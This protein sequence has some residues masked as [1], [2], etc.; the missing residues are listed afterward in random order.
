MLCLGFTDNSRHILQV[1][2]A[3]LACKQM[4]VHVCNCMNVI[5]YAT[6]MLAP[7]FAFGWLHSLAS[8]CS[9]LATVDGQTAP[10]TLQNHLYEQSGPALPLSDCTWRSSRSIVPQKVKVK[11]L[12]G[13]RMRVNFTDKQ[14]PTSSGISSEANIGESN[15]MKAPISE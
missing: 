9:F 7:P 8:V 10:T 5:R 3:K 1:Q 11:T 14:S 13:L 15:V 2:A 4:V 6:A 12:E